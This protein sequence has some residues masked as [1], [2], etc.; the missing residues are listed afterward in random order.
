MQNRHNSSSEIVLVPA[1][2]GAPKR[3]TDAPSRAVAGFLPPKLVTFPSADGLFTIHAQLFVPR[4]TDKM[5]AAATAG[6][7]AV[8]THGGCERQ[9]YAAFHYD[10]TYGALYALNQYLATVLGPV[11]SINYR[12]G[13]LLAWVC[14]PPLS[15]AAP[16][17]VYARCDQPCTEARALL[18]ARLAVTLIGLLAP[19]P[20]P[21]RPGLR[22]GVPGCK[23]ERLAG[24][25]RVQRR[26]GRR[27]GTSPF[28]LIL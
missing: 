16:L 2:G 15:S 9:M 24:R 20:V 7:A 25:Q 13:R 11:L 23:R 10:A 14:C 5:A 21:T 8:F 17:A 22:G 27:E 28:G 6:P 19:H 12:G 3:I 1:D 18:G 4:A 26:A